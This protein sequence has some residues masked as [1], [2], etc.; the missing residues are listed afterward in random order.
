MQEV[1]LAQYA[2]VSK[3][4]LSKKKVSKLFQYIDIT[5]PDFQT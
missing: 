1:F 2:C 4:N 5:L 3:I